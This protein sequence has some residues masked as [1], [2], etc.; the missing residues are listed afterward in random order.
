[1]PGQYVVVLF[2]E[3]DDTSGIILKSWLKGDG[4]LWPRQTKY[5]HS[6]LKAKA[7]PGADWI[8]VPCTVVR[9]FDTYAEARANLPRVENGSNLDGEAEL[10]K[11]RRKK[12]KRSYESED[13]EG[14]PSPPASMIRRR[15]HKRPRNLENRPLP[16]QPRSLEHE[17][18]VRRN[19]P[20]TKKNDIECVIK[21]WLR[22]AG[23]KL[24]KQR[25]RT[26]RTH[27]EGEFYYLCC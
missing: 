1:M 16:T 19:F 25:L 3:E 24:Q 20:E 23:E 12:N 21:V 14:A 15:K 8:E 6:L 17:E 22:H 5:V 10:G 13:D 7:T 2:P 9:E 4:C 11:G 26:S 27:H 18:A